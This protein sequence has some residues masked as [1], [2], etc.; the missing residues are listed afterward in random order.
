M[1]RRHEIGRGTFI[2]EN[3]NSPGKCD[4]D[5]EEDP[6]ILSCVGEWNHCCGDDEQF[7]NT[8]PTEVLDFYLAFISVSMDDIKRI[9]SMSRGQKKI[10]CRK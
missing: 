1:I 7:M 2:A 4:E 3:D 9:H 10:F 5:H 6:F 8:M